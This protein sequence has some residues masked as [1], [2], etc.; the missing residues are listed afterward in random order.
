MASDTP[1]S[2]WT[3]QGAQDYE[4][5]WGAASGSAAAAVGV[6]SGEDS[7]ATT[8]LRSR[9]ASVCR[10]SV[11]S[12]ESS[13]YSL[14]SSLLA[15][16]SNA[17]CPASESYGHPAA[18]GCVVRPCDQP[19]C[20][21]WTESCR[22]SATGQAEH[23]GQLRRTGGVWGTE[24]AQHQ[25]DLELPA[26]VPVGAGGVPSFLSGMARHDR[27]PDEAR[28]LDRVQSVQLGYKEWGQV[29]TKINTHTL[30]IRN[31]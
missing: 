4:L 13:V 17:W 11:F 27:E 20:L 12:A 26:L 31:G 23:V 1:R 14:R 3:Q 10:S 6:G 8:T 19:R 21:Q 9:S 24:P 16:C 5:T 22:Q 7:R 2:T 15:R 29:A 28:L 30:P 18:V 25:Q